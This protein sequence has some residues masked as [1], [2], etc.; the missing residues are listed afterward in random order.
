[1]V[2]FGSLPPCRAIVI[3]S[4]TSRATSS[5]ALVVQ[6]S[7]MMAC[8][9]CTRTKASDLLL[10]QI[11]CAIQIQFQSA[12]VFISN[13]LH[14]F[15]A[16][17]L[18]R[19]PTRE[20]VVLMPLSARLS[21]RLDWHVQQQTASCINSTAYKTTIRHA[22]RR[23]AGEPGASTMHVRDAER[24]AR[25]VANNHRSDALEAELIW[26]LPGGTTR[27][28]IASVWQFSCLALRL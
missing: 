13:A 11:K 3:P 8:T 28:S 7:R 1:M 10:R 5:A 18:G 25:C 9:A 12:Q 2:L 17:N 19:Y 15:T 20:R 26:G 14:R 21:C 24:A 6:L 22:R 4:S 23:T 16:P 27:K